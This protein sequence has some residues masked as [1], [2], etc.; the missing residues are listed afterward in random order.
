[1]KIDFLKNRTVIFF[2][3]FLIL[4]G[5]PF[6]INDNYYLHLIILSGIFTILVSGYNLILGYVG[7]FSLAHTAWFGIGAYTSA[8]LSTK[9]GV[10]FWVGLLAAGI[11]SCFSVLII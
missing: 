9:L 4:L 2:I 3:V 7:F 6:L 10:P 1:M 11:L 5:V 8:L